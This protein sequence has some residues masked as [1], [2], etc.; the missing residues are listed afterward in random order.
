MAILGCLCAVRVVCP[1]C[2]ALDDMAVSYAAAI[3]DRKLGE[4]Y[5]CCFCRYIYYIFNL[6][7]FKRP[8]FANSSMAD[9]ECTHYSHRKPSKARQTDTFIRF[10]PASNS[11][12]R[13]T[14][15]CRRAWQRRK[16]SAEWEFSSY[17]IQLS[18]I[19]QI[20]WYGSCSHEHYRTSHSAHIDYGVRM[21]LTAL[22]AEL[23]CRKYDW[24][25][26]ISMEMFDRQI[27]IYINAVV[28]W[29]LWPQSER[30]GAGESIYFCR[31][32]DI[33]ND[34]IQCAASCRI[35]WPII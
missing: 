27:Q 6:A 23:C 21:R 31:H 33:M 19:W 34:N 9:S 17:E 26:I 5:M 2:R 3:G 35:C 22:M 1:V 7:Y 20:M 12:A 16:F 25:W 29:L 13:S 30:R 8:I 18:G 4:H 10:A 24:W 11:L 28:A 15:D 32:I 14:C